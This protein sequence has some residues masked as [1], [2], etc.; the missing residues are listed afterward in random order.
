MANE[1]HNRC[2]TSFIIKESQMTVEMGYH[3]T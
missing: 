2:S 3:A 1:H